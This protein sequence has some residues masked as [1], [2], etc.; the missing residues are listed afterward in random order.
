M[1]LLCH[2]MMEILQNDANGGHNLLYHGNALDR[3]LTRL[4]PVRSV[5][6]LLRIDHC[7]RWSLRSYI[8]IKVRVRNRGN[9]HTA[10][11]HIRN[12]GGSRTRLQIRVQVEVLLS[13]VEHPRLIIRLCP[14]VAPDQQQEVFG[15]ILRQSLR[16]DLRT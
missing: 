13:M 12:Y 10:H 2:D 9:A 8:R 4:K 5:L 6:D 3:R 11:S 16:K 7:A 15:L 14:V 1:I